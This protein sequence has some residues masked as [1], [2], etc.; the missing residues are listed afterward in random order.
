MSWSAKTRKRRRGRAI[1]RAARRSRM[2]RR[3]Y[4]H[5]SPS[6]T[7]YVTVTLMAQTDGITVA[8]QRASMD[9][10]RMARGVE[11]ATKYFAWPHA[12]HVPIAVRRAR[13]QLLSNGGKP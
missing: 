5:P 2:L 9:I 6:A 4:P 3:H 7:G 1:R 13:R 10:A 8:M 11:L 12:S